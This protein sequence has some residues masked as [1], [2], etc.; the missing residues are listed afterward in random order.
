MIGRLVAFDTTS[1]ESNLA[2]IDFVRDYLDRW[3]VKSELVFDAAAAQ[4][5]SL[6][7]HRPDR[8]RGG[9]MLSGHSDVVPVD[10]QDWT[11]DPFTLAQRDGKLYGAR[12][13]RYEKLHR[14]DAGEGAG[15]RR[16]RARRAN[17][18]RAHL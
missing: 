5:Q 3:R 6:R 2:L 18:S 14:G 10:G 13:R 7:H 8:Y 9:V 11:S 17:P 1:R 12:Q 15:A 4:G 16:P